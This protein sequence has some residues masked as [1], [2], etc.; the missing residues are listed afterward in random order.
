M[1]LCE[2]STHKFNVRPDN[3]VLHFSILT[4][5]TWILNS[6]KGDFYQVSMMK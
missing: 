1:D 4:V 6:Q 5:G 2:V 3:M